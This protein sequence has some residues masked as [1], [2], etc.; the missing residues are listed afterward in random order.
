MTDQQIRTLDLGK[1]CKTLAASY[2]SISGVYLFGSRRY[3]SGSLR[4]D[5]DLFVEALGDVRPADLRSLVAKQCPALDIFI[6]NRGV[7]RSVVNETYVEKDTNADVLTSRNA[8]CLWSR[9][10][11]LTDEVSLLAQDYLADIDYRMTVLPNTVVGA[12]IDALKRRLQTEGLPTDP[13]LGET[14][15]EVVERLIETAKRIAIFKMRD[16]PNRATDARAFAVTP[17]SEYDLQDLFWISVK[18]WVGG[19]VRE[20]VEIKFDGQAKTSD[21]S[22]NASRVIIEMKF[23]KTKADKREIAKTLEGLS[24]FYSENA[25]V[26][27]VVFI[28][29]AREAADIDPTIWQGRYQKAHTTPAVRLEIIRVD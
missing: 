14:T 4:S 2:P 13:M 25:N 28:I 12:P 1:F 3:G 27:Y 29:Y 23:A 22:F 16:F 15:E 9:A 17:S 6:L 10:N 5:I 20:A 19:M 24:R 8:V 11:G 18:P 21:F 7:A 26:T